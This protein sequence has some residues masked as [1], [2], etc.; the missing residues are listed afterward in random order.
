MVCAPFSV[1][2]DVFAEDSVAL[3]G[4]LKGNDARAIESEAVGPHEQCSGGLAC[5]TVARLLCHALLQLSPQSK[6]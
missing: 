1:A 5:W 6:A 3:T 2:L 4:L